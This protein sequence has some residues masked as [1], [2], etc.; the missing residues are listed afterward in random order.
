MVKPLS[1]MYL[2]LVCWSAGILNMIRIIIMYIH[3]NHK[4][5]VSYIWAIFFIYHMFFNNNFSKS[6]KII[7]IIQSLTSF[8]NDSL[9]ASCLRAGVL[10]MSAGIITGIIGDT[11]W[12]QILQPISH[13]IIL[14]YPCAFKLLS[15]QTASSVLIL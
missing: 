14:R 7:N 10:I 1:E 4:I 5:N 3:K 9:H 15:H 6:S 13:C 12:Q 2:L 8:P 11:P